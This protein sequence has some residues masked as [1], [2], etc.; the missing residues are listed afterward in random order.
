MTEAELPQ[1]TEP[2]LE[3]RKSVRRRWRLVLVTRKRQKPGLAE[4]KIDRM[5]FQCKLTPQGAQG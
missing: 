5:E 1:P 3:S 2:E 4:E